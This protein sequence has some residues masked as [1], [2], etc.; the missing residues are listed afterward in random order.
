MSELVNKATMKKLFLMVL[1]DWPIM[2][3]G[4]FF[5]IGASVAEIFLPMFT[6]KVITG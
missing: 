1:P 2:T 5:L 3:L 6:G 4:L